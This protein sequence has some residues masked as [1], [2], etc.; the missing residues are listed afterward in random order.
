MAWIS[1]QVLVE[2]DSLSSLGFEPS[3]IVNV[4]DT[5]RA[6]FCPECNRVILISPQFGMMCK[7]CALLTYRPSTSY[8]E[9]SHARISALRELERAWEESDR[10]YSL[11]WSDSLA[12]FDPDSFSWKTCQPSLFEGW[13]EFSWSSLRWGIVRDGLLSQ[14]QRLEPRTSESG[15]SCW[16]TPRASD[17]NGPG[18]GKNTQGGPNLRTAVRLATP[19]ASMK[20]RSEKFREGRTPSAQEEVIGP[21]N[22]EFVEWLMGYPLGWTALDASATAWFRSK[23]ER[24]SKG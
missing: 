24:R 5:F 11:T 23:R 16:P 3:P 4:N 6:S 18:I 1:F 19:T 7:L 15:G 13:T 9:D 8:S 12:R 22:P 10:A 20:R 2:S 21:L 14:P 17:C